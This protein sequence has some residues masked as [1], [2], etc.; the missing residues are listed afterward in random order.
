MATTPRPLLLATVLA[1]L[2]IPTVACGMPAAQETHATHAT[3]A[4][5]AAN[6]EAWAGQQ[7]RLHGVRVADLAGRI[8][9]LGEVAG[10]PGPLALVFIDPGCPVSNRYAPELNALHDRALDAGVAFYGVVSDPLLTAAEAQAFVADYGFAFPVLFDSAGDL[11]LRLDPQIAV[12]AFV[13]TTDDRVIYRGRIDD[14]FARIGVLRNSFEHHDLQA[15]LDALGQGRA[16]APRRTQAVGCVF[17][18]WDEARLD[19]VSYNR[20]IQPLLAANCVECHR[21][22]AVAPFAL[23]SFA[24]AARRAR[25]M[26]WVTADGIMPPWRAAEGFGAFRGQRHLSE[27]QVALFAA[28]AEAGA[29]R[30]RAEDALPATVWPD[31]DVEWRTGTPDMVLEMTQAFPVPAG[32]PDIYRYF[33]VPFEL[34]RGRALTAVEFLPGDISVVHHANLFVDYSGRARSRDAEDAEP[35]FS[36]FGTGSFFDYSGE[37]EAWGIGGY[38]PGMDPYVLP[39][40][41]AVWLRQGG[42]DLVLEVHYHPNGRAAEDRSRVGLHFGDGPVQHWVDG[43]LIGTQEISIPPERDD[44]WRHVRMNV[45]AGITLIDILP[46]MHYL[47]AEAKAV[48]TLPDGSQ[49]PLIHIPAWD[50]RWQNLYAFREPVHLPAGS[51]IDGWMRFD[52]TTANPYNPTLPPKTVTWGWGSDEEM[53][54]FWISFVPDDPGKRDRIIAAS[55]QSFYRDATLYGPVP[56]LDDLTPASTGTG[57]RTPRSPRAT[58]R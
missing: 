58:C 4:P 42:G 33:V 16:P 38:V 8:H 6:G 23:D 37:A 20:H 49:L 31:S 24:L 1:A 36:V 19:E 25:M 15:V 35:G 21:A 29:P 34:E 57:T 17:E 11:A 47:G 39:E 14:R 53:A 44:Y 48:A 41:H 3:A 12:E 2:V 5:T 32:G 22:G 30:G 56:D 52:N 46:H 54:E 7:V 10:E 55:W 27:R 9:H 13:V 50:L 28:W 26:A 51:C 18:A 45:P 40:G 43:L